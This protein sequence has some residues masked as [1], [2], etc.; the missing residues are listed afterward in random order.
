MNQKRIKGDKNGKIKR[1]NE[2]Y[3]I[4]RQLYDMSDFNLSRTVYFDGW[5]VVVSGFLCLIMV[6][7]EEIHE[8]KLREIK[9]R[10]QLAN[11]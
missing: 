9:C 5:L 1:R 4:M 10:L 3:P 7:L 8:E 11:Y 6:S 2:T